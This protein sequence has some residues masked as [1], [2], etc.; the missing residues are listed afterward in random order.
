MG[1]YVSIDDA[2]WEITD[3][4]RSLQAIR[5]MPEKYH[6]IKRGGDSN[7]NKW[8]SWMSDE[9]I[10]EAKCVQDVF[11]ALGFETEKTEKGFRIVGYNSKTGQEDLFLAVMAPWTNEDSYIIWRGEDG[12]MWKNRIEHKRML[13]QEASIQWGVAQRYAYRHLHIPASSSINRITSH[14]MLVDPFSNTLGE[15]LKQIEELNAENQKYW[16]EFRQ[17]VKEA[18][19][20]AI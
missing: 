16:A 3:N 19:E 14:E 12:E 17:K 2:D 6:A 10:K 4:G 8:F 7:G 1:Y 5:E 18:N 9:Q 11:N 15:E 20:E 13:V